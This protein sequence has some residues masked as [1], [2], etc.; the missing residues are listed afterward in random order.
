M[1]TAYISL[2]S[3][4]G[5]RELN[6]KNA[7]RGMVTPLMHVTG[8]LPLYETVPVGETLQPVPLYLNC[9]VRIET[10]LPP[11]ELLDTLQQLEKTGGR[12]KTVRWGPRSIDADILLYDNLSIETERLTIPHPRLFERAFV[13][14]P[15]SYIDP[16]LMLP[17]G[18]ALQERLQNPGI[19][20][21]VIKLWSAESS[22]AIS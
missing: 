9:V 7:I 17:D 12:R 21:Q 11:H 4:L 3:N 13:L 16:D 6:L 15:L 5:N 1:S 14:S 20:E 22:Y 19:R 2:G 10:S 18:S 8:C